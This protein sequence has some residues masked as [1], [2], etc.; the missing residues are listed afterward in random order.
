MSSVLQIVT[1]ATLNQQAQV[2]SPM[3][4]DQEMTHSQ[5]RVDESCQ[6]D[7]TAVAFTMVNLIN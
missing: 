2:D 1:P 5:E 7:E 6:V 3:V 4:L